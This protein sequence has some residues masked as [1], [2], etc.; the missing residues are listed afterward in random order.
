MQGQ[1][2]IYMDGVNF[3]SQFEDAAKSKV[4]GKVGY[5][6]LPSGPGGHFS[7]IYI[8]GMAVNAQSRNKEAAYLFCQ[9][10]TN[11]ANAVRELMA[12][13][14]VGRTSTWDSPEVKA[15]PK[16]P[17]DWYQAYQASLKIGRQGLPEI[18]G[19]TEYRDIIGVAIQKAIE[20]APPAQVLA[21]AQKDFQEMLNRT[22]G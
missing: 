14:G 11:K 8:T 12:G 4:V 22:E 17:A 5:A 18:V 2:A 7:P 6:V 9:W 20:G 21:Q 19:V 13:V 16:M 1:V 10:A 3:A 15:K